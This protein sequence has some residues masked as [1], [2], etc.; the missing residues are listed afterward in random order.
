[1]YSPLL[2]LPNELLQTVASNLRSR[3]LKSLALCCKRLAHVAQEQLNLDLYIKMNSVYPLFNR[4]HPE[5]GGPLP[6]PEKSQIYS[7]SIHLPYLLQA[8]L[9]FFHNPD[10]ARKVKTI[11]LVLGGWY[12]MREEDEFYGFDLAS[13]LAREF[14]QHTRG[15]DEIMEVLSEEPCNRYPSMTTQALWRGDMYV[16]AEILLCLLPGIE[17]VVVICCG[18]SHEN[19]AC[20]CEAFYKKTHVKNINYDR[21]ADRLPVLG[22]DWK[23][24]SPGHGLGKLKHLELRC[25]AVEQAKAAALH[26]SNLQGTCHLDARL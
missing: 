2:N 14:W 12:G 13:Y 26:E 23:E 25:H 5:A 3:E 9:R 21:L 4:A 17:E 15:L 18:D 11:E 6:N 8:V 10:L 24:K 1:M 7:L 20:E 16:W 22:Y 19:G